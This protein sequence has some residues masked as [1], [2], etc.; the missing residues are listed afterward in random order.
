M[1]AK[2]REMNYGLPDIGREIFVKIQNSYYVSPEQRGFIL[3]HRVQ[4]YKGDYSTWKIICHT[5]ENL[6][7]AFFKDTEWCYLSEIDEVLSE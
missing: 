3:G 1:K 2:W 4:I 7:N 6:E 5:G